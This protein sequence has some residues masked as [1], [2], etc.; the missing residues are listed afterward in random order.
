ML[1]NENYNPYQA[2][3]FYASA[4]FHEF[5]KTYSTTSGNEESE[6]GSTSNTFT[7]QID[8]W[9]LAAAFGAED[10][11]ASQFAYSDPVNP[12]K[13]TSGQVL[14]GNVAAISF[15]GNLAIGL[16]GDVDVIRD[17][18]KVIKI[19]TVC[20]ELGFPRLKGKMNVGAVTA[21]AVTLAS[22]MADL[23]DDFPV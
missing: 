22:F 11:I 8:G 9:L 3:D 17:P 16:T 2:S 14:K 12:V 13:I 4:E 18:K 6:D 5:L 19:A 1:L 7:R 10:Y 15:L 20:A 23:S 21:P